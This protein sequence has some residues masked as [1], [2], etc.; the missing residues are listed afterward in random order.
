MV[1]ASTQSAMDKKGTFQAVLFAGAVVSLVGCAA[2]RAGFMEG[3]TSW[4]AQNNYFLVGTN[5]INFGYRQMK[6]LQGY[7][8]T[9]GG[10][11]EGHGLPDFIYAYKTEPGYGG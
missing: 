2:W 7:H 5:S 6:Y 10:F 4:K 11:V 8:P 1:E 3:Y 9:I